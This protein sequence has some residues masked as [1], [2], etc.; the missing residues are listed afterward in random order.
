[1][2]FGKAYELLHLGNDITVK[3]RKVMFNAQSD[4]NDQAEKGNP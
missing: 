4:Q 3:I 2:E 1:M